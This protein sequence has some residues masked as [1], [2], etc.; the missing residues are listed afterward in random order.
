MKKFV[1]LVWLTASFFYSRAQLQ[2]IG[3]WR[4]HLPYH[5]A[6]AVSGSSNQIFAATPYSVFSVQ[7]LDNSLHAFSKMTGLSATGVSTIAF[8]VST[9]K[10]I[11]AY[12]NSDIDILKDDLIKNIHAFKESSVAG[13]KRI[14]QIYCLNGK[15]YLCTGIGIVVVD[16]EKYEIR[17]T[18]V[19]GSTGQQTRVNAL[20]SDKYK[21]Y[22]ATVEGLKWAATS[23]TNLS[24]YHNWQLES[25]INGLSAGPIT[26][27][28]VLTD[29]HPIVLKND[30]LLIKQSSGWNLFYSSGRH[31]QSIT[32]S[33]SQLVVCEG[34]QS[35]ARVVI[36]NADGSVSKVIQNG[37]I[38]RP[39]QAYA[40]GND[41]W[42]AD[43]SS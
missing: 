33:S 28:E 4:E 14:F 38:V 21:F 36:L 24:D 43:S 37:A 41:V 9:N 11:I 10:L 22:A 15:A 6:I 27:V 40:V 18:Y 26:G 23:S 39:M 31:I 20:T 32:K 34:L 8:D 16:E 30:S 7:L 25:S 3:S 29:D 35:T 12:L 1:C 17:E 13:D 42:I 2:P 5:Q 19:I